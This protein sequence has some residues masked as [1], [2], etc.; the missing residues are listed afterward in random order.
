MSPTRTLVSI[1][2][3]LYNEAATLRD[4]VGRARQ[5]MRAVEER[6]D[7]ELVLVDDGSTDESLGVA[8]ELTANEPRLRVIELR[9]NFGQTAAL[10][11]GLASARGEIVVSMDS[12][13]QHFPEDIP[14][15][16]AKLDEGYDIACGWRHDRREGLLRRWPSRAANLLVRRISGLSIHDVGTTFRA[17]RADMLGHLRL[18]G[19]QHRFVPVLAQAVGA[20]IT[21]VKIQNIERP[22]GRSNYGL[23]RTFGVALDL[24]F[25]HFLLRYLDRPLRAFGKIAFVLF[26]AA[27]AISAWLV[28][29][30]FVSGVATVREHSGWFLLAILFFLASLQLV[31]AG[32]LAEI[33]VR[34]H[35]RVSGND[36]YVIRRE[37]THADGPERR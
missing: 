20:R 9:R 17:Y 4:F 26:V 14:A 37:W 29:Y 3:P 22:A 32:I 27:S 21:E 25:L 19:D 10:Q 18:L 5:A 8:R 23:A 13:L 11:A 33:L 7:F 15:L 24:L 12:D 35:Y 6:Y 1:V 34:V 31:L 30:S 16:L 2:A 28:G 36:G